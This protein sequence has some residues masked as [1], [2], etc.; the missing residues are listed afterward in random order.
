K[1][2]VIH[3]GEGDTK[4]SMKSLVPVRL[5]KNDFFRQVEEAEQR[6]ASQEELKALL[7]RG[8]AKK[9]MFEGDLIEGELE[10]GEVA[11]S[12][13]DIKPAAQ[14]VKEIWE[15]FLREKGRICRY[16]L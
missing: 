2:A 6:G 3:A 11:G 16:M 5:L 4:L 7:G 12:I 15:E 8:R 10:I 14:I 1:Q 9:G 13:N